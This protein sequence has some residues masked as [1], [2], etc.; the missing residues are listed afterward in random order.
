[1]S[2][3]ATPAASICPS[4]KL[5]IRSRTAGLSDCT[6]TFS[7]LL[8]S[9][10]MLVRRD[11]VIFRIITDG[12]CRWALAIRNER[13]HS[14][15]GADLDVCRQATRARSYTPSAFGVPCI[16][17]TAHSLA[18]HG[19]LAAN[20][21]GHGCRLWDPNLIVTHAPASTS[22]RRDKRARARGRRPHLFLPP[23]LPLSFLQDLDWFVERPLS[24]FFSRPGVIPLSRR[25]HL[26]QPACFPS[27]EQHR[28]PA[29]LVL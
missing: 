6:P 2:V 24:A 28:P 5:E 15:L 23:S 26:V 21:P 17:H 27:F 3:R 22:P 12:G 29:S 7:C 11:W 25:C 4:D 16:T 10:P 18:L 8:V 9:M 13:P 1:M 14:G 19:N 20:P